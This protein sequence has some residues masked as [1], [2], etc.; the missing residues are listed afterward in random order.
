MSCGF[1]C[2]AQIKCYALPANVPMP[3][4]QH[5]HQIVGDLG[6]QHAETRGIEFRE[7]R[8]WFGSENGCS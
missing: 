7:K 4:Q 6:R 1:W 5:L 8:L 3:A 2:Y